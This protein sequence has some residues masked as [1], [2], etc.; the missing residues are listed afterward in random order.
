EGQGCCGA[1]HAHAGRLDGARQLAR[2]NIELFERLAPDYL[3]V[4]SAGC[5]AAMKHYDRLLAHDPEWAE[6]ARRFSGRV[7]DVHELLEELGWEKP[8]SSDR[9]LTY[10]DACHLAHGQGVTAAPRAIMASLGRLVELP[11]A[12]RCCGS[13]G[14]YNLTQPETAAQ[15]LE[16][17]V[18]QIESTGAEVVGVAN[19]GCLLQIRHGL[20]MRGSRVRAEHPMVLLAEA[21]GRT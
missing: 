12:D 17:K 20:R 15:L 19:P 9:V 8:P 14:T 11:K 2:R 16:D 4:N 1:L 6:A 18:D 5:G 10:H 3:A 21:Y 13:A 7:R